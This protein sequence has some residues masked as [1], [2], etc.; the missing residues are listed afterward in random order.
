MPAC[1]YCAGNR[2]IEYGPVPGSTVV[3]AAAGTVDFAGSVAG[4]RWLVVRHPDGRRA[5]YG[6]L[7]SLTV[8]AGDRVRVGQRLGTTTDRFY[9]G[10]R[11]GEEPIDPTPLLGRLRHRARL[12]PA[13]GS[14][15]RPAGPPRLVCPI[16]SRAR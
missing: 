5:S 15:A 12:V 11:D 14:P 8:G 10:L 4:T 16:G 1:R 6:H 3:A 13:D 2:G 7:A 9:L